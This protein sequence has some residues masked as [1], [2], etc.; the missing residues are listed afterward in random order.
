MRLE[1]PGAIARFPRLLE[2]IGQ[3]PK[4][5]KEFIQ[6]AKTVP[7]WMFIRWISQMLALLDKQ[8]GSA[9]IGILME[10]YKIIISCKAYLPFHVRLGEHI[11]QL[12]ITLSKS[13]AN[14]CAPP[15]LLWSINSSQYSNTHYLV[16]P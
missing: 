15:L 10:V 6:K 1:A 8:E 14:V 4:I 12:C 3:F 13:V 5:S 2:I 11:R 7:C 16:S 9:V